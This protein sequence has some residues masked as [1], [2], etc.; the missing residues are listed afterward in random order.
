M[1]GN[2][3]NIGDDLPTEEQANPISHLVAPETPSQPECSA[4]PTRRGQ[5]SIRRMVG[6]VGGAVGDHL[7][8]SP[9]VKT[10]FKSIFLI[11]KLPESNGE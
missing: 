10:V 3:G 9:V 2:I 4:R 6:V 7:V 5:R 8:T 11:H 1:S